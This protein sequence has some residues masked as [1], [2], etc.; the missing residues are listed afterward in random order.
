MCCFKRKTF[1][2]F[3]MYQLKL[4]IYLTYMF[5]SLLN[6]FFKLSYILNYHVNFF[7]LSYIIIKLFY[8]HLKVDFNPDTSYMYTK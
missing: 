8:L 1:H 2:R 5:S 4:G 7:K 6:Y 3:V